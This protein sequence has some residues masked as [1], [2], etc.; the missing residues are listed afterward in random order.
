MQSQDFDVIAT[1]TV[2][3]DVVLVQDQLMC[4]RD[5]ASPAHARMGLELGHGILQLQHKT[6]RAGRIVFGDESGDF[7]DGSKRRLGPLDGRGSSAVFGEHRFDLPVG[8]EFTCVGFLDAFVNV[9]NLPGFTW[10]IVGQR[11]DCHKALAPCGRFG[12]LFRSPWP[13]LQSGCKA[14]RA[15]AR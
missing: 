8:G 15:G 14:P 12:K 13:A 6:G 4:A 2:N 11:G 5:S 10:H 1:H 7:I 3:G 9:K